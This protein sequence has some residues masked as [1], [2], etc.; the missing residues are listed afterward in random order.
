MFKSLKSLIHL[1]PLIIG[2]IVLLVLILVIS[3]LNN[4]D[5][6]K[7]DLGRVLCIAVIEI[8]LLI[9]IVF[10]RRR[11]SF[12]K[13][14]IRDTKKIIRPI[15]AEA[16]INKKI[17]VKNVVMTCIIGLINKGN[18]K[19]IDNDKI[20]LITK[21][22]LEDY[23]K[24]ILDLLFLQNEQIISFKQIKNIFIYDNIKTEEFTNKFKNIK[25]TIINKLF[26]DG[27]YSDEGEN[28]LKI[29]N[30]INICILYIIF[31][32]TFVDK[33]SSVDASMA[34]LLMITP[35]FSIALKSIEKQKYEEK[36]PLSIKIT[37]SFIFAYPLSMNL[38]IGEI[39]IFISTLILLIINIINMNLVNTHIFTLKGKEEYIK[40][41]CL[42]A[43]IQDYGLLEE[44]DIES[45]SV[46]EDYLAYAVAFGIPN[47]VTDKFSEGLLNLN[48]ALQEIDKEF[49]I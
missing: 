20:Q 11:T 42:K 8:I 31:I 17:D 26:D 3:P 45:S 14:Y 12:K 5:I 16:I 30:K 10:L 49:K 33:I 29:I 15:L 34:V 48:L 32:Y 21:D 41:Q 46:W 19:V 6:N 39:T 4:F 43:Y 18:L 44:K 2:C 1:I 36:I 28:K 27:I 13:K 47:K 40:V 23:E 35:V 37:I 25:K 24:Q 22:N 38:L 7:T 9:R